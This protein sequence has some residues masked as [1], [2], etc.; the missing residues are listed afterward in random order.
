LFL[1][2]GIIDHETGTRDIRNISGLR[3][4][5][6]VTTVIG[7]LAALSGMGIIPFIGFIG[8]E[9]LYEATLLSGEYSTLFITITVIS[10]INIFAV[11]AYSGILP[12]FGEYKSPAEHVSEAPFQMTSGP[13]ALALLGLVFGLFAG[14][15]VDGLTNKALQSIFPSASHH[16]ALFHGFNLPLLLSALTIAVGL[17]FVFKRNS[18][19]EFIEKIRIPEFFFPSKWY[20]YAFNGTLS[21]AEIQTKFLQNGHL[22]YYIF[23]ILALF[24]LLVGGSFFG[25]NTSESILNAFAI[26]IE[27]SLAGIDIYDISML[28]TVLIASVFALISQGRLSAIAS[29]GIV[30]ALISLIYIIYGAPDLAMT[31]LSIETLSVILFVL[32]LYKLPR[33]FTYSKLKTRIRDLVIALAFGSIFT[34]IIIF[35]SAYGKFDSGLSEY[36]AQTSYLI[37]HG[38]NIVN[39]ILV[40]FRGFDTMGE[41]TVLAIAAVGVYSLLRLRKQGGEQ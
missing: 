13:I 8:K 1:T 14:S 9:M 39:V 6:P 17:L 31:Q 38:K 28:I 20:D 4:Y 21:F 7:V 15:T 41:I 2:A 30:G 37:G 40:D 26:S 36:F 33:F 10:A 32:V 3:K 12:F 22:R 29:M 23:T 34:I 27:R 19:V 25:F 35:V 16:L 5:L 11:M 24:I 18:L